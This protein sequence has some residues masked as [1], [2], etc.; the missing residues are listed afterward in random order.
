MKFYRLT[1]EAYFSLSEIFVNDRS[2]YPAPPL[3][4][5][6]K[7]SVGEAEMY[8]RRFCA[9]LAHSACG[10]AEDGGGYRGNHLRLHRKSQL[11]RCPRLLRT[12]FATKNLVARYG[13]WD[14]HR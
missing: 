11:E 13:G 1:G 7:V 5:V 3:Y 14:W 12:S 2:H 8:E 4:L 6:E 10:K 9:I